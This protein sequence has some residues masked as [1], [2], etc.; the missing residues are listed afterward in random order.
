MNSERNVKKKKE[1]VKAHDYGQ[2]PDVEKHLS[3]IELHTTHIYLTI[4]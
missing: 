2:S 3:V 1:N 4:F